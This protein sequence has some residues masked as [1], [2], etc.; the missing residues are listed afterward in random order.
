MPTGVESCNGCKLSALALDQKRHETA[1]AGQ[2]IP[3]QIIPIK[4]KNDPS[5]LRSCAFAAPLAFR[6]LPV[7][8][9]NNIQHTYDAIK[10]AS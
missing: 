2:N 10:I 9:S 3:S 8:S 5:I 4:K 7:T 1:C 6:E